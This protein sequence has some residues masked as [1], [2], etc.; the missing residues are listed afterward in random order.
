MSTP[1][2]DMQDDD[3]GSISIA[4]ARAAQAATDKVYG[5]KGREATGR[6][7]TLFSEPCPKCN[8]TGTYYGVSRFGRECFKCDGK[9]VLL[10]KRPKA[11]RDAAKEKAIARKDKKMADNLA[12]VEAEYPALKA[13]W[14]DSTFEFAVDLRGT[15]QRFGRLTDGQRDAALRA[16][17]KYAAICAERSAKV[18]AE[19]SRIAALP[20]LD[21]SHITTAF[22][23]ARA[24]GVKRPKL[25]LY[26]NDQKF[27][28]SRAPDTGKNAGAVYVVDENDEYMG[29]I[30]A[31]KF[32]KSYT[33]K[34]EMEAA[35]IAICQDPAQAAVAYGQRFGSCGI[36]GRELTDGDSIDRGIGPICASKFGF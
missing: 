2:E 4:D 10:F 17:E 19:S 35:I 18:A 36:C 23:K 32:H 8:G 6:E 22:E 1:F 9:G 14:T 34:P 24:N 15:A 26:A 7:E 29:K 20:T 12:R 11:V 30:V 16:A 25:R 5:K 28:F 3:V 33:C 21:I 13:W 27:T 31:G